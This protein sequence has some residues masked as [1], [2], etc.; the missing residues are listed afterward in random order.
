MYMYMYIYTLYIAYSF[1]F[2]R[3]LFLKIYYTVL[4]LFISLEKSQKW[5][6]IS[7]S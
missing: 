2:S 7:S 4:N 6:L 5:Y 3:L 1:L